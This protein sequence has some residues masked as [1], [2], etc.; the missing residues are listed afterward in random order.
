MKTCPICKTNIEKTNQEYCL[1][2]AWEF[3]YFFDDLSEDEKKKYTHR[4][5]LY[6]SIYNS[7]KDTEY[8]KELEAQILELKKVRE[9]I[10]EETEITSLKDIETNDLIVIDNVMYQKVSFYNYN[11]MDWSMAK[12]NSNMNYKEYKFK[13]GYAYNDWRL[14]TV[15]ELCKLLKFK[16]NLSQKTNFFW[17]EEEVDDNHVWAIKIED[18]EKYS[19]L[20]SSKN[21]VVYVRDIKEEEL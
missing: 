12:E 17:T 3:E 7:S 20:K 2:C 10:I 1:N 5:K 13:Y 14:P 15:E 19:V 4:I 11:K 9:D 8:I 6:S 18:E 16:K 21:F